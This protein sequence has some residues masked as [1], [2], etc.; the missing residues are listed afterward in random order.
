MAVL[1]LAALAP[2]PACPSDDAATGAQDVPD[3]GVP[4]LALGV[5]ADTGFGGSKDVPI[6][7]DA[8]PDTGVGPCVTPGGLLCECQSN[9][10][11]GSGYCVETGNG[12]VCTDT[13]LENCPEGFAC[14]LLSNSGSDVTYLC[15]PRFPHLC[16]PCRS[17]NDC[18]GYYGSGNRCVPTGGGATGSF[19]GTVCTSDEDCPAEYECAEA[20]PDA[21]KQCVPREG[22]C[23]CS[24]SAIASG[25][26]TA[27]SVTNEAGT[28]AGVRACASIGLLECDA[29]EPLVEECNGKDDDC[30]GMVDDDL[31]E[32]ECT[33]DTP[34]GPCPA[35]MVCT[36]GVLKCQGDGPAAEVCN[37]K[38]DDCDGETD[39]EGAFGCNIFFADVDGDGHGLATDTRCLCEPTVGHDASNAGDCDDEDPSVY[40]GATEIC[41]G[42]DD[43]CNGQKDPEGSDGCTVYFQ[44]VDGDGAGLL[45]DAQCLCVPKAPYTASEGGDC[46]DTNPAVLPGAPEKCNN[47]DDDCNGVVDDEG[48]KG[49]L[50][51]MKDADVDGYG[52]D[53]EGACICSPKYPF[54]ALKGGD[55]D[56]VDA[57]VHPDTV[58]KCNGKDDDCNGLLDEESAIGCSLFLLDADGDGFGVAGDVRCLC[59]PAAPYSASA[60]GDCN[61]KNPA[62]YP[63]GIEVCD[64]VDNDCNG[65]V[66]ESGASGCAQYFKDVDKDGFGV[67]GTALCLCGPKGQNTA[68]LEGD[69]DDTNPAASPSGDEVCNTLDDDCDGVVDNEGATGCKVYLTDEDGDGFGV[70]GS[71]HCLCAA[72]KPHTA[73][74][75]GDCDDKDPDAWPGAAERCNGKDDDCDGEVDEGAAISCVPYW[76]DEDQDGFGVGKS[77]CACM[78]DGLVSATQDGDCDDDAQDVYPGASEV[79]NGVDDDCDGIADEAFSCPQ[80]DVDTA[81][82]ACG[83]CGS[84]SRSRVCDASCG[85]SAW[86]AWGECAGEGECQAGAYQNEQETLPCGNCGGQL[87]QRTRVCSGMCGWQP[88]SDWIDIGVC[89]GEGTCAAGA[90]ETE[91]QQIPCGLCGTQT[92]QRTRTCSQGCGWGGWSAWTNV[93]VC[94]GA[95]VCNPGK[96]DTETM[97]EPCGACGTQQWQRTRTCTDGC[98]LDAWSEWVKVGT[99]AGEGACM[100]GVVDTETRFV[101]CGY[102]GMQQQKRTRQCS[103]SC[104][105]GG[106]SEWSDVGVCEGGGECT[107]GQGETEN[108]VEPCGNCGSQHKTRSRVCAASCGW[109]PWSQWLDVGSCQAS[110]VCSAGASDKETTTVPCGFCGTQTQ[111]R[112]RLCDA[113]CAWGEFSQWADVGSCQGP[114]VC[115]PGEEQSES[116]QIPCGNCGIQS[117]TRTRSC[118]AQCGWGPWS[119]W[120][121]DGTCQGSGPCTQGQVD[122]QLGAVACG[123]CGQ[124]QQSRSRVCDVSCQWG[125]FEPWQTIGGCVGSG[126]CEA[127]TVDVDHQTVSCGLCGTQQQSR[128]RTCAAGCFW[129]SWGSWTNDTSCTGEGVCLAGTTEDQ[130]QYVSCGSC[131]QQ[132]QTR[133]RTCASGCQWAPWSPWQNAGVCTG[134]GTCAPGAMETQEQWVSCGACGQQK[135][136]RTRSCSGACGWG[137][138]EPW[139]NVGS[140]TTEG[141]CSPGES[142]TQEQ[143][144]SCGSCGTQTQTRTRTCASSCSWGTWSAWDTG[145][146]CLGQGVCS[147]GQS[148][149]QTQWVS[150]GSCGQQQQQRTRTCDGTC[151]WGSF[152]AWQNVGTCTGQ[153]VCAPGS[154]ESQDQ[155]VT[156]GYCGQQ[157]QTRSH[158]CTSSCS[159]GTW[160]SWQNVGSC[161][162]Q[163]VC[164]SGQTES[165]NQTVSCGNC[166]SQSQTRSRTC[167]TSCSWGT[168]GSWQNVGSCSGQGVCSP[169]ATESQTQYVSCGLCGSQLQVRT[170]T[171]TSSCGWGAWSSW[172]N[173]GSCT[174]QG[175]CSPGAK[176]MESQ[177]A[178][179][180]GCSS[181]EQERTRTCSTSCQWG[182]WGSWVNV[183]NC[184]SSCSCSWNSGTNWRCCGHHKWQYCLSAGVWSSACAAFSDGA[185][186]CP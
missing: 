56:D 86:G 22:E 27:C 15:L 130:E 102:C 122:T 64:G 171:C 181:R 116:Q 6:V 107:A 39:E 178:A 79:C 177:I 33:V 50:F 18:Q 110:G 93:G 45:G 161:L 112:T 23:S 123:Y 81:T 10:D 92:Q 149:T 29:A 32:I 94:E 186:Q 40:P 175:V 34:A 4:D 52:L 125:A 119:P 109:E 28:C 68:L 8:G 48:S 11:C 135:Q 185:N 140:C 41:N 97:M 87:R 173:S 20:I 36:K 154:A 59:D 101:S 67:A 128:E 90:V 9:K 60:P 139:Q 84:R 73:T 157:Q 126:S 63:G 142:E 167:S 72:S 1:A 44:D 54:T 113:G 42:K 153:G 179:C 170:R 168:W 162:N 160:G 25:L 24:S 26:D 124:Q 47:I 104:G 74:K 14:A 37:G 12:Q 111:E 78:P 136:T 147:V 88:W 165:Q 30:D 61:D 105:W 108:T 71:L 183:Y 13:C 143:P 98:L 62:V 55:C 16:D 158:T 132:K 121:N 38:D 155:W 100:A 152:G 53:A 31:P 77:T 80:G 145:A 120:T 95:G 172:Q 180:S 127:G 118:S 141:V 69:C 169:G 70:T 49:C 166:G 174:G 163:G 134:E 137:A 66:D 76:L 91:T 85:Y 176:Q 89:A 133:T 138:W 99:C 65:L 83:K 58:E 75:G 43:N 150:C 146:P 182:A 184:P 129:G 82:E 17:D 117:Q 106:W 19:C 115:A 51:Y 7:Y 148:D 114:G 164:G 5:A 57:T 144:V 131:G 21:P 103:D 46:N 35:V 96:V 159:W 3:A 151:S 156:C 2:L